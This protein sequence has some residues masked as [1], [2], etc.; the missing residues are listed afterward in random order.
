MLSS[1]TAVSPSWVCARIR[2]RA[3]AEMARCGRGGL[4]VC[5]EV[6]GVGRC[7]VWSE[8]LLSDNSWN[9]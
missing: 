3:S 7:R 6:V 1:D 5:V 4:Y 9:V 2:V 8:S